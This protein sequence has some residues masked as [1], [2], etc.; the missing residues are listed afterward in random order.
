MAPYRERPPITL[1]LLQRGRER[2][3]IYCSPC[4]DHS[5]YGEAWCRA[6][7][8]RIRRA[9]M[10]RVCAASPS[11]LLLRRDHQRLRGDVLLRRRACRRRTAGRSPPISARCRS[12]RAQR[13]ALAARGSRAARGGARARRPKQFG[14]GLMCR[15]PAARLSGLPAQRLCRTVARRPCSLPE[16]WLRSL[17]SLPC[18]P[19]REWRC[20]PGLQRHSSGAAC[21]SVRL[22][23]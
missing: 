1:A 18:W 2:F 4:H 16:S 11:R 6:A 20:A 8:S 15:T 23:C 19:T 9:S 3:G 10:T 13:P 22:H 12:A 21:R 14:G 5:G 7:A 17:F